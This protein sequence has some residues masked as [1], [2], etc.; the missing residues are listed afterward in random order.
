M[1]GIVWL[2][3]A[4]V[5]ALVLRRPAALV[6]VALA[7]LLSGVTVSFLQQAFDRRRPPLVLPHVHVLL[8]LIH[9]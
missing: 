8:S 7:A 6:A 5:L 9:I 3:L 4:L 2:A 1:G